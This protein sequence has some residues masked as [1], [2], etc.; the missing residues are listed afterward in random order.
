MNQDPISITTATYDAIADVFAERWQKRGGIAADVV[1]FAELLPQGS[2]VCDVGCGSGFDTA[3]LRKK[4]LTAIGLDRSWGMMQVGRTEYGLNQPFAQV[5]M[6]ALP[7]GKTAVAGLWVCASLLHLPREDVAPTL[8]NFARVL[9]PGGILYLSVKQGDD[10]SWL[11]NP[12]QD[13]LPR[14]FTYW[15]PETLDPLLIQAGFTII[16]G[17]EK[18]GSRDR[19]LVRFA[20]NNRKS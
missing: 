3:V 14:F 11:P 6:R 19:W 9:K 18:Q 10:A 1:R 8:Q 5:D 17:W 2:L 20:E 7:L 13:D 16:D 15:Q 12:Y 4:G